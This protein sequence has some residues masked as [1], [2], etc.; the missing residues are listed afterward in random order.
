M[1]QHSWRH[2]SELRPDELAEIVKTTPTAYWPLGLLEH[3]GWHL[4][5]GFDGIKAER[6]CERLA[7]RTGGVVLPVMWWGGA[8]GHGDF[9]WTLYQS[10]DAARDIVINTTERLITFGFRNI[11]LLMG[12]YPWEGIAGKP[13][14]ALQSRYPQALILWGT[15]A[16]IG[17]PDLYLPGDHA[18]REETSYGLSLLPDL[19]KMTALTTGRDESAWPYATPVAPDKRYPGV[20]YDPADPLF[21]QMGEDARTATAERGEAAISHLV[22]VLAQR[23][24]TH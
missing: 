14:D 17:R 21:A 7:Q 12:H 3:H 10:E 6:L 15:E 19:V 13:L 22:D 11:V 9:L 24:L 16:T 20:R 1:D 23:I 4:P 18:A 5:V 8:G 2:Y